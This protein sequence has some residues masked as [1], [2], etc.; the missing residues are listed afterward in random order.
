M[1]RPLVITAAPT[2]FDADGGIDLAGSVRIVEHALAAG[3][4]SVLIGG[5]TAEF[6]ALSR[7]E[8][9]R[10]VGASL[11]SAGAER[12]I[13]HVGASSAYGATLLTRDAIQ[14]GA[15]SLAAL[16]PFYLPASTDGVRRY[17]AAVRESAP[18]DAAATAS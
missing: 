8:R 16:T 1:T 11:A 10:L 18:A 12:I 5:T 6:P 14:L 17:M 4:D 9:G 3:V 15:T 2:A 7:E 13:A